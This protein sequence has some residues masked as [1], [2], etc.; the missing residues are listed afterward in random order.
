MKLCRDAARGATLWG[1]TS[2]T[3][4]M[5]LAATA[6]SG[7]WLPVGVPAERVERAQQLVDEGTEALRERQFGAAQVKFSLAYDLAPLAA[8]LDGQGCVALLRGE[9]QRAEELFKEAL[10]SDGSYR[11]ALAN[12]ALLYDVTGRSSEAMGLYDRFL[13]Q[14]PDEAS[15]R[16][17]RA[18]LAYDLSADGEWVGDELSKASLLVDDGVVVGNLQVVGRIAE[19]RHDKKGDQGTK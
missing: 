2:I 7:C 15:V 17:N 10:E 5:L 13:E 18:A 6:L 16:N 14:H 19:E 3:R 8:A 1:A 11:R 9:Y 12:L 4:Y